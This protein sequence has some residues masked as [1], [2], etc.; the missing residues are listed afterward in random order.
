MRDFCFSLFSLAHFRQ[1]REFFAFQ[2]YPMELKNPPNVRLCVC[3]LCVC[4]SFKKRVC[5]V[6]RYSSSETETHWKTDTQTHWMRW[7]Q[8]HQQ[9][10]NT[11][12]NTTRYTH[13]HI[14]TLC[15]KSLYLSSRILSKFKKIVGIFIFWFF[16]DTHR[17]RERKIKTRPSWSAAWQATELGL[18][19]QRLG[20]WKKKKKPRRRTERAAFLSLW[21]YPLSSLLYIFQLWRHDS[22]ALLA[23]DRR[24]RGGPTD[25]TLVWWGPFC[26]MFQRFFFLILNWP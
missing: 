24:R 20:G 25:G 10:Q 12:L 17:E 15:G 11:P 18:D 23:R 21:R 14:H 13:T 1:A 6:G 16:S 19:T 8:A 9:Q 3:V 2:M 26:Y 4:F 7:K 5:V 22:N